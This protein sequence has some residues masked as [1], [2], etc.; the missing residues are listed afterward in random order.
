MEL[1]GKV[2]RGFFV[3][4]LAGEQYA[5]PEAVEELRA[6]KLRGDSAAAEPMVLLNAC[7]PA[8]PFGGLLGLA[9]AAGEDIRFK[10][11]P[12]NYI[13]LRAGQPLAVLDHGVH[14]LADL[15]PAEA[16]ETVRLFTAK[17][18]CHVNHWNG[19]PIDV[20]PARHLLVKLGFVKGSTRWKGYVYDG[21]HAPTAATV[22][23]A[24]SEVPE[25]FE[26]SGKERAPVEYDTEW[27]ISRSEPTIRPKVRELIDYLQLEL[28]EEC[29]FAC[30]PRDMIVRYRGVRCIHPQIQRKRIYLQVTDSGWVRGIPIDP[31]T[32]LGADAFRT[33]FEEQFRRTCE[34]I[35]DRLE[36]MAERASR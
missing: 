25:T 22:A 21:T 9:D 31:D 35:D 23:A 27:I 15:T 19:H 14:L 4:E 36:R 20:S 11:L 33:E 34:R 17:G 12:T 3:E 30:R 26:R 18:P 1:L 29:G 6:A 24:D 16:E 8:N 7:D 13:V 32:D 28:P 5:R 10:R 2:R